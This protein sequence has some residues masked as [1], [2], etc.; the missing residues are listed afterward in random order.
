MEEM[1][2]KK[3]CKQC[4]LVKFMGTMT[5]TKQVHLGPNA[6]ISIVQYVSLP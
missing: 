5:S 3:C 1:F 4:G 6:P 2:K